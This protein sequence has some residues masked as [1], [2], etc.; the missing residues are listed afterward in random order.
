VLQGD[1]LFM[2]LCW[3]AEQMGVWHSV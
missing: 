3:A 2:V 1:A